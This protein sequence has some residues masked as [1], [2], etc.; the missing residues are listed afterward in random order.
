MKIGLHM[1][2]KVYATHLAMQGVDE[3]VLQRLIGH[4]KGSRVTRQFYIQ[5]DKQALL[6]TVFELP[7]EEQDEN[8][9]QGT[10]AIFGNDR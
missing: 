6:E 2:R 3:S 5:A 9:S 7:F 4:A 1:F 10:L 8:E